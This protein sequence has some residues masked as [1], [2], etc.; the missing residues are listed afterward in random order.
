M[1]NRGGRLFYETIR[2][3]NP[4]EHAQSKYSY[5]CF[6]NVWIYITYQRKM[7]HTKTEIQ[8]YHEKDTA[9]FISHFRILSSFF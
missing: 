6:R 7:G 5:D 1:F 9:I 4:H 2:D 8:L 3:P